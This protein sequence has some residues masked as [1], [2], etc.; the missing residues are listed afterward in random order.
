MK[1]TYTFKDGET[2]TKTAKGFICSWRDTDETYENLGD[3][4]CDLADGDKK[5]ACELF[6]LDAELYGVE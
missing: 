3:L 1:N 6:G 4:V 2:V 5:E